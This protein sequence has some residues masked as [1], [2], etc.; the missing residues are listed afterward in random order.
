M[1]SGVDAGGAHVALRV[2]PRAANARALARGPC[3]TRHE[4]CFALG[5]RLIAL[6]L[7]WSIII[8][9][10][11]FATEPSPSATPFHSLGSSSLDGAESVPAIERGQRV[12]DGFYLRMSAGGG[13]IG[14]DLNPEPGYADHSADG[15]GLSFE[16]LAGASPVRGGTLGGALLLDLAPSMP[17]ATDAQEETDAPLGLGVLGPFVDAFP[18]PDLGW[19]FGG[20]LGL[21][22]LSLQTVDSRRHRLVG[23]GGA[24]WGGNDFWIGDEWSMGGALRV[25]RTLTW[26]DAGDFE[27]KASSLS[28]SLMLTAVHH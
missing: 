15:A 5:M 23:V 17:L 20:A 25:L 21:A 11:A 10:P 7:S 8:A 19:H 2:A 22:S 12:H 13:L 4:E 18:E 9:R 28:A 3:P 16:L 26:G 24:L 14:V 27:L 6:A 1:S